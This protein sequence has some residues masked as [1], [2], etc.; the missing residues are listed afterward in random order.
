M[1][2]VTRTLPGGCEAVYVWFEAMH[3]RVDMLM[4]AQATSS[5]R[6]IE[7]AEEV[8]SLL[9]RLEKAGNRFDPGS[10][11]SQLCA[12]PWGM[13]VAVS[14]ELFD[15]LRQCMDYHAATG[16]LFDITVGTPGHMPHTTIGAVCLCK[17][18]STC[19]LMQPGMVLDLSG[20][21]K[22]Y[23]LDLIRPMLLELGIGDA[24]VS[25]GNSSVMAMGDVPGPVSEG[26]LTTSGHSSSSRRHIVNPL[27]G[28]Y[29]SGEGT[30]Q[31]R[32]FSGAEGEV[33]ATCRFIQNYS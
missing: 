32:T 21:I 6:L 30:A 19:T 25:L 8:R 15:M 11:I 17:E 16:G 2:Y 28:E 18:N 23:A 20:F 24:L 4:K 12:A 5:D 3:T 7:V 27:T 9:A 14:D 1:Q 26:C 31:V 13:P 29:V 33:L 22:G 10:E